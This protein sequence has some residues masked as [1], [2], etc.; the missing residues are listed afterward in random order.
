MATAQFATRDA[1]TPDGTEGYEGTPATVPQ[2]GNHVHFRGDAG[3]VAS[4]DD[5]IAWERHI[6]AT[7]DDPTALYPR[8]SAPVT[9]TNGAPR[10]T[11]SASHA[12]RSSA[13]T[14]SATAVRCAGGAAIGSTSRPSACRSW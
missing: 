13:A 5:M 10:R 6:D 12:A 7:R 9:F 2:R 1:W 3:L 11:A 8:L 14:S 4:L